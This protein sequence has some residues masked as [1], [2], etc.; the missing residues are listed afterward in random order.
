MISADMLFIQ[1]QQAAA[2]AHIAQSQTKQ[3]HQDTDTCGCD[4]DAGAGR[5]LHV[6]HGLDNT[7]P[8]LLALSVTT[9]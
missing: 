3:K 5:V 8:R 4:A 1:L 7:L 2:H 9:T 6:R